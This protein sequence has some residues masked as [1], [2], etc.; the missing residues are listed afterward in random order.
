MAVVESGGSSG[1][2]TEEEEEEEEAGSPGEVLERSLET[3]VAA[4]ELEMSVERRTSM[5]EIEDLLELSDSEREPTGHC[6][7]KL[8]RDQSHDALAPHP[9]VHFRCGSVDIRSSNENEGAHP[10]KTEVHWTFGDN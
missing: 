8:T 2:S 4:M 3:E 7:T 10:Q 5:D 6:S 9:G 1:C